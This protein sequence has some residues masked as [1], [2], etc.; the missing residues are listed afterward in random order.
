MLRAL[1][2]HSHP[3]YITAVCAAVRNLAGGTCDVVNSQQDILHT[4]CVAL[5][6]RAV[7]CNLDHPVGRDLTQPQPHP[8]LIVLRSGTRGRKSCGEQEELW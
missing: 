7:V 6:R 8:P 2:A 4:N 5:T 1:I 3:C